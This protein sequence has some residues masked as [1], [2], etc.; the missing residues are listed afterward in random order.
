MTWLRIGRTALIPREN[1]SSLQS[2]SWSEVLEN[3]Y[4]I[5]DTFN[6]IPPGDFVFQIIV[7]NSFSF[8]HKISSMRALFV[9]SPTGYR[10]Y[11]WN[12]NCSPNFTCS[13][14]LS[15]KALFH[16][17]TTTVETPDTIHIC[18]T[19][20]NTENM[21]LWFIF[22]SN[23]IR[24]ESGKLSE[25]K[26]IRNQK[27]KENSRESLCNTS[28]IAIHQPLRTHEKRIWKSSHKFDEAWFWIFI[29]REK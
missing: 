10:I 26:R 29:R 28:Q 8:S 7:S 14:D 23:P 13:P 4:F 16:N 12:E 6:S 19:R 2:R 21:S 20:E 5:S 18:W 22:R 9:I 24:L 3:K 11:V 15:Y 1:W 25:M 17:Y 27:E